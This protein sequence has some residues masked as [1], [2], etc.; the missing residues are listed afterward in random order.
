[1]AQHATLGAAPRR[2]L[3]WLAAHGELRHLP[4]GA[5]V[6]VKG[7]PVT[8]LYVVLSG[9]IVIHMDRG[10]VRH[11]VMEWRGGAVTGLLPYSRMGMAPGD[12]MTQEPSDVLAIP[13]ADLPE[14]IRECYQV[15]SILVHVM[16]DRARVFNSSQLQDEKMISL[17]KMS[18]RLAHELNNPVSAIERNAALLDERLD[19]AE[20]SA[21]ALGAAH[22]DDAQQSAVD[23]IRACCL[24]SPVQGVLSPLAQAEREEN[25]ADWLVQHG[26]DAAVALPLAETNVTI[27]ALDRLAGTVDGESLEVIVRWAAAGCSVHQL[28][29]DIRDAATRISALVSAV[30]GFTHMD[31]DLAPEPVDLRTSLG[32]TVTV[33]NAKA[34]EKSA[35]ITVSVPADLPKARGFIGELNQIWAN[36]I[37]NALDAIPKGGR[38]DVAAE[39][40]QGGV[41]VRVIDNGPGIP[42]EILDHL[43]EPFFTTKAVGQGTGLGLEIVQRLVKHNDANIEIESTP[44]RTE[45]RVTL[46]I[47]ESSGQRRR[48]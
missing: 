8:E 4:T 35:A 23:A 19:E 17:G 20:R 14:L 27:E 36:L 24:G 13:G 32:N 1:L 9:H 39:R 2:E 6:A 7:Q 30:K 37:D 12:S 28:A 3:E 40:S 45:F 44:G 25:V 46:P 38:V 43:F 11:K 47:A 22:L 26:V 18:A 42:A 5:V 31:Q 10:A 21:R 16:V 15:T 29:S 48:E 41:V 33:L 34:R